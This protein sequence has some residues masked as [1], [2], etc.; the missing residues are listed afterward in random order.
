M[1]G[2]DV[3]EVIGVLIVAF[4]LGVII[5]LTLTFLFVKYR[6]GA[7]EMYATA[8]AIRAGKVELLPWSSAS[9]GELT[10]E[11][12]GSSTYT[13]SMFGRNDQAAGLVP[14]SKSQTGWLLGFA[15][16]SRK[17]GADGTVVAITSAHKLELSMTAGT[18]SAT[19]N[20]SALG[21]VKLG[22]AGEASLFG[23]D[24]AQV[25]SYR[26]QVTGGQ[27]MLNGREVGTLARTTSSMERAPSNTPLISNLAA[28]SQDESWILTLAVVQ[29]A[30]VGPGVGAV[31]N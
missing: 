2:Q 3:V 18:F 12:V 14:S 6:G 31:A 26:R 30:W 25:G 7:E 17:D 19:V 10:S 28:Q 20:G 23:P 16:D 8:A 27:L 22:D 5:P 13:R 11:W 24:G 15:T 4:I 9:L 1:T 29:F 21:T